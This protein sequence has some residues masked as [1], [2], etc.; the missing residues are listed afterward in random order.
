MATIQD[1][2]YVIVSALDVTKA[3]DCK[4][5]S[6]SSEANVQIWNRNDSDAQLIHI[7][8]NSDGSRMLRFAMSQKCIDVA[9]GLFADGTN[10]QQ[11]S[12]NQSQ[13]QEWSFVD[14]ASVVSTGGVSYETFYIAN[15]KNTGFVLD[16]AHG[17][18]TVGT[19]VQLYHANQTT[20]QKW[21]LIPQNPIPTGT[22]LIRSSLDTKAVLDVSGG[23]SANGANVQLYGSNESNAQIWM[24]RTYDSSGLTN[25][26]NLGSKKVLDIDGGVVENFRNVQQYEDNGSN[27]QKWGLEPNGTAV[28]NGETVGTYRIHAFSGSGFV[29]DAAGGTT[30]P[31]TNIQIY[32]SNGTKAQNWYFQPYSIYVTNLGTPSDILVNGQEQVADVDIAYP[33]WI[34]NGTNYQCRYRTRRRPVG[35]SLADWSAWCSLKDGDESNY[36]WGDVGIANTVVGD[37]ARK[38]SSLGVTVP[39]IDNSTYDYA[40]IQFEVR[41]FEPNYNGEL[42]LCAHGDSCTQTIGFSKSPT[43]EINSIIWSPIGLIVDY[44]SSYKADG[45]SLSVNA[46]KYG[47]TILCDTTYFGGQPSSGTLE[48]PVKDLLLMPEESITVNV[49]LTLIT[50]TNSTVT[51]TKSVVIT[52]EEGKSLAISPNYI[53]NPNSYTYTATIQKHDSDKCYI[54]IPTLENVYGY[55]MVECDEVGSSDSLREFLII[56]PLNS[57][58]EV[59]WMCQ[60]GSSWNSVTN[61]MSKVACHWHIWNWD[62]AVGNV[63]TILKYNV[64]ESPKQTDT[65]TP[66][67]SKFLTTNRDL[68]MFSYEGTRSQTLDIDG[69]VDDNEEDENANV[70]AFQYFKQAKHAIYRKTNGEWHYVAILGITISHEDKGYSSVTVNQEA[71]A[72]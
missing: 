32:Q 16:A 50:K 26:V 67:N 8:T 20:A 46:I 51:A 69:A 14:A 15:F 55:K 13:A 61:S 54:R 70:K 63:C 4:G 49:S 44:A 62:D 72:L 65:S 18:S 12:N 17:Q 36:G 7:T 33:S 25:I 10:I 23:S 11:N 68:P 53:F 38:V 1:G 29:L 64:G 66:E 39:S 71:E 22:Y 42:G 41:R 31:M 52:S 30:T 19:N 6:D 48:L 57:D 28:F 43:L 9:H 35:G 21:A 59:C 2:T 56:P 24:V 60:S 40:E 37:T 47:E 34:C 45:N 5:A 58:Y 27:A 3:I